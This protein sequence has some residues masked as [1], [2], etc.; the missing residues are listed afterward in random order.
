MDALKEFLERQLLY[1]SWNATR[2]DRM[3]CMNQAF[4]AVQFFSLYTHTSAE[5]SDIETLWEE[6]KAKFEE[7]VYGVL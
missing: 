2:K 4:G 3:N 1:C 6:Y 5:W 7:L